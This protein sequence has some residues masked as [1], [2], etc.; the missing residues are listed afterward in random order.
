[1]AR[2]DVRGGLP[3]S[4]IKFCPHDPFNSDCIS[5]RRIK[6]DDGSES[7]ALQL[8][9]EEFSR[10]KNYFLNSNFLK[11]QTIITGPYY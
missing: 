6:N 7:D 8:D 10:W 3:R 1:M 11:R 4:K 9:P 2:G 5:R